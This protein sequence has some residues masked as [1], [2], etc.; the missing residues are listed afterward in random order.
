MKTIL[1]SIVA[2]LLIFTQLS[3]QAQITFQ[4]TFGGTADDAAYS[5]QQTS[6]N[7]YIITGYTYNFSAGIQ[8]VYLTKTN[9]TGDTLWTKTFGGTGSDYGYSVQQTT[10]GGYIIAGYTSSFGAGDK[11]VY[12]IKTTSSGDTLWTRT[13]GGNQVDIG[14][15]IQQTTDGGYI[16]AGYTSSF[17]LENMDVYLIK[18]AS[19]GDIVWTKTYGGNNNDVG[20]SVKQTAD[21]GF[22]IAGWTYSFGSG[23][24]DVYLIKTTADGDTSW[25]KTY[26]GANGDYGYS[27]QQ[28]ADGGYIISGET[29]SFGAGSDDAYLIR[30]DASGT[31]IWSKTFGETD[32]DFGYSV[33]PTTD[34][35]YIVAGYTYGTSGNDKYVYLLK[36]AANGDTLWTKTFGGATGD[37]RGYSVQQTTDGGYIISGNT[38][39][40]GAGNYD[41]YL[42]KTDSNGNSGCFQSG[43]STIITTAATITTYPLTILTNP[44][45]SA[46]IPATKVGSGSTV[47]TLCTS[48]GINELITNN[49][50]SISPNPFTASIFISSINQKAAFI[51]YDLMGKE[52]IRMATFD[53]E[54]TLNTEQ[55]ADG[56]YFYEFRS[57][58]GTLKTGKV[59]KH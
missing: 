26:G 23:S 10:D 47:T 3:T 24:N 29:L 40:F 46:A 56:I 49:S 59:V 18:T 7:G 50:F 12:L 53:G 5:V 38:N 6:E 45:T 37:A 41:F 14:Y 16:I 58:K 51:L 27:V 2:V 34:G 30:T 17:D 9:A 28:T 1:Y 22:I 31:P 35:G 57:N 15:S 13:F 4:K 48:V 20:Y 55:L 42:I 32:E 25:T 19:T 54:T 52:V 44:A 39:N 33:Q 36:T 8:D 11:D 43:S 21:G